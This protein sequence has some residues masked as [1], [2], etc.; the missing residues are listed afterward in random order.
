MV[1]TPEGKRPTDTKAQTVG[2]A[3]SR[4]RSNLAFLLN[5]LA[6]LAV[7][8]GVIFWGMEEHQQGFLL[9]A[10]GVGAC[11]AGTTLGVLT[12]IAQACAA[13]GNRT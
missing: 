9:F 2:L 11:I 7:I 1:A 13:R 8:G 6:V 10:A 12:E 3:Y 4:F 5:A